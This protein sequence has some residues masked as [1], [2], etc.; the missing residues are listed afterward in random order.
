MTP[1]F[2][3]WTLISALVTLLCSVS[4]VWAESAD[5]NN[6]IN[7][8]AG[9]E[10]F[11]NDRQLKNKDLI[12]F[13][14]EHRYNQNWAAEFF[15]ADSSPRVKGG[16]EKI[17]L[18]Q[19]G[20]DAL[21]YF[22]TYDDTN[23]QP[24]GALGIGVSDFDTNAGS[25]E[26][27]QARVGLGFRY[28]LGD[29]WSF[30]GDTRL[31]Y[32][33]ESHTIDNTLTVGLS[34]AFSQQKRMAKPVS[35][36][37]EKDSDGD[38]VLDGADQCPN[39]PAGV[40]VDSKGCVL[41]SDGDGVADYR[42]NCPGTGAGIAVDGAGCPLDS[43]GDGVPD[44]K[45][46]C[47]DS[48]AGVA[49]NDNGCTPDDDNDG[50]NNS[51][52]QCPSTAAGASVDLKGCMLDNDGDGVGNHIDRCPTTPAGRQ[53]DEKGCKFVLTRTE[54]ITLKINFP[55]N[56]S[57][58]SEDQ[59]SEI[60]RVAKFLQKYGDV[61]TVIEGHTDDRGAADYNQKLSQSRANAVRNV[62][63]ERYGIAASRVSA[64][65]FGESRPI[66]TNDTRAGRLAN[67]RVVAVIEAQITE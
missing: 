2:K 18:T 30:R 28:L 11:D 16:S 56:S 65:G 62:L 51:A 34:Y 35:V 25:N 26:E 15:L 41:D 29:H 61:N 37:V 39:T 40:S 31:L 57:G 5:S 17:D 38:G 7:F 46:Q 60:D 44:H 59:L 14:F 20:I 49:V 52:D 10:D 67:R 9:I 4:T 48:P 43:D 19:Y 64:E 13:G 42:D 45:D 58:I 54:E 6:Y 3:M 22:D 36:M 1:Q 63:I 53:V 8:A 66:E 47:P 32:S 23:V 12:S 50:V 21:Y 33:E 27:T 24:Y 55:S